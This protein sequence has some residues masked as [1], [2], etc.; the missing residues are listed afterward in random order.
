MMLTFLYHVR[1][2]YKVSRNLRSG[3]HIYT[4]EEYNKILCY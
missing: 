2:L 1:N 3:I 4:V